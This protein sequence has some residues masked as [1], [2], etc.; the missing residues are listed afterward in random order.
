LPSVLGYAW[1]RY[2]PSR[3]AAGVTINNGGSINVIF[4]VGMAATRDGAHAAGD[5]LIAIITGML[6]RHDVRQPE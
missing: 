5:T 1:Q 2:D 4:D 6:H 3:R